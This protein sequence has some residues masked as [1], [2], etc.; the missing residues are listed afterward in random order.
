MNSQL[1]FEI[2]DLRQQ[3]VQGLL[4]GIGVLMSGIII[5]SVLPQLLLKFVYTDQA[6]L[7][8]G[9]PPFWLQDGPLFILTASALYIIYV[10]V[11]TMMASRKIAMLKQQLA[12][13]GAEPAFSGSELAA[14]EK[15]LAALEK[16]VD[17]ALADDKKVS[18]EPRKGRGRPAKK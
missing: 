9:E 17:E 1:Q 8:A 2:S 3:N 15:E 4:S 6:A 13:I 18:K 14:Q 12:M 5:S 16:M 7:M 10:F 11:M